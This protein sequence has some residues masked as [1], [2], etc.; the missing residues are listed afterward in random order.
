[1]NSD[2]PRRKRFEPNAVSVAT[3]RLGAKLCHRRSAA[4]DR[5]GAAMLRNQQNPRTRSKPPANL[6]RRYGYFKKA[7]DGYANHCLSR[8]SFARRPGVWALHE[9][10]RYEPTRESAVH[11][12]GPHHRRAHRELAQLL[13][14]PRGQQADTRVWVIA[15][16]YERMTSLHLARFVCLWPKGCLRKR[17][18]RLSWATARSIS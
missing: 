15:T 13:R 18:S 4:L 9:G 11:R 7:F 8:P 1:M 6:Q 12:E 2:V 17:A 14:P 10:G 16:T 5:S 3:I